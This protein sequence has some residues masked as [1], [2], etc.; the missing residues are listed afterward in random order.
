MGKPRAPKSS[1]KRKPTGIAQPMNVSFEISDA[2]NVQKASRCQVTKL[3]YEYIKENDLLDSRDRRFFY[4]DMKL[5]R[6]FGPH[7]VK[8]FAMSSFLGRHLTPLEDDNQ[9]QVT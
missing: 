3:L 5:T 2:V 9:P 8:V 4:P 7:R 6:I 1:Q